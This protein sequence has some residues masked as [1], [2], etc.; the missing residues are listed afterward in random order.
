MLRNLKEDPV[1]KVTLASLVKDLQSLAS[2]S[3]K[4][5]YISQICLNWNYTECIRPAMLDYVDDQ[6][7]LELQFIGE[8]PVTIDW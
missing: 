6:S 2:L 7:K 8:F 4:I 3:C 5:L 1:Q